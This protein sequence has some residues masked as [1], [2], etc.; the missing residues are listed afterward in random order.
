MQ[1]NT[2]RKKFKGEIE[3]YLI[4]RHNN[5]D[6]KVST[7][8]S[9]LNLK[10][11]LCRTNIIK[12][13]G[14]HASHILFVLIVLPLLRLKT[15]H[16]FCEKH[17]HSWSS[18]RKDTFYRFKQNTKYRWRAFMYKINIEIFQH[19]DFERIP[20]EERYF[21]I[22]DTNLAKAGRKLENVSYIFDHNLNRHILGFCV[23]TL[24]LFT[25]KGFYPLDFAYRFGKR[26]HPKSPNEK[27]GDPRSS[28]GL[29]SYEAKHYT[30][31]EL[32]LMMIENAV[33]RGTIPGYV[34]FD[35]W[36][37]WPTVINTIRKLNDTIHVICRLK[38]SNVQ[39]EYN[40]AKYKLS[41]LY[42]Q[43]KNKFKKDIRT[44]LHLSRI[45]VKLPGSEEESVIVFSKGYCE[46]EDDKI[47]GKKK[48][49]KEKWVAFLSTNTV[50]HSSTIIKKYIKR[51]PIEVC[52]K[53]CKQML[54]LGKDQSND[55]NAQVFAT[56]ASFLR[57]NIL[58]YLNQMENYPTLGALFEDT[59]DE[60]AVIS[61]AHRLWDFFYGLLQISFS[62]IFE[63]FE[64]EDD[65]QSYIDTLTESLTALAPFE[66]CET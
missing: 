25:S 22:D 21:V 45:K 51:W 26:R 52:F 24:G 54:D 12:Q 20:Q 2:N 43:I 10:T 56:T 28:S 60:S 62:K 46:P 30:K 31:L 34:M 32:A 19:L 27:I 15:I 48:G 38:N 66:G 44:G 36:Y 41:E 1:I 5:F 11:W 63:L 9:A 16:S 13:D 29:R 57:Y 65:F 6:S 33:K 40:G 35:S 42:Q 47:K 14:Y 49:K 59:A 18:S 61:Y 3:N 7:V 37:A 64:I 58:N 23:V 55:F 8:F 39:Y 4:N 50:L 17:W 53:E